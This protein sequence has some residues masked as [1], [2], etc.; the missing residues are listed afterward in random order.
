MHLANSFLKKQG[1]T[2]VSKKEHFVEIN[3]TVGE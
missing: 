1:P 3:G 2:N